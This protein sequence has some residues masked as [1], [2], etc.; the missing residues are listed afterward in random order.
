M[1]SSSSWL[2]AVEGHQQVGAH[3]GA[4]HLPGEDLF[5]QVLLG[6]DDD[7]L[8]K[9]LEGLGV[10]VI[11]LE[12]GHRGDTGGQV[13]KGD[14]EAHRGLGGRDELEGHLGDDAQG[15]LGADHQVQQAVTRAGLGHGGAEV[16]DLAGGQD[17]GHG[18]HIIPG[19]AVL[20]G[21]HAAG[22]GGHVAAQG[23]QL[24]AGIGGIQQPW[25]RASSASSWS[26]TP[27]CTVT[28]KFSRS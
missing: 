15:A 8:V 6:G 14:D 13:F 5:A 11:H 18:L 27:G 16:D 10:E 12:L 26:S 20:D 19:G 24:L 1:S 22:V 25:A 7:F 17:H 21:P 3:L 23:S 9:E 28:A 4:L 2:S